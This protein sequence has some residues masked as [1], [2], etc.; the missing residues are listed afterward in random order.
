[1]LVA[2]ALEKLYER[3][4]DLVAVQIVTLGSALGILVG[5]LLI[6]A[7]RKFWEDWLSV[8]RKAAFDIT[9]F[10]QYLGWIDLYLTRHGQSTATAAVRP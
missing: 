6:N 2:L 7:G 4:S 8:R 9:N 3:I 5:I 1:M 10:A